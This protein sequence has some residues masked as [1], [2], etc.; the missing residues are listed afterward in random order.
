L[1]AFVNV[2]LD[3]EFVVRGLKI[4]NGPNGYFVCMPSRKQADGTHRDICHPINNKS[5]EHLE[6][7]IL[8]AYEA[9]LKKNGNGQP[10]DLDSVRL[11]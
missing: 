5:R 8:S 10:P 1:R 9:E 2:T 7:T 11:H 3:G 6:K 4:I